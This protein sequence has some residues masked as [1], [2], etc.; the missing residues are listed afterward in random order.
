MRLTI[1]HLALLTPAILGAQAPNLA[2]TWTISL[3]RSTFGPLPSPTYDTARVTR[4]GNLYQIESVSDFAGQGGTR[5]TYAWPVADG[6][7]TNDMTSG[8]TI[9]VTTKMHGDTITFSNTVTVQGQAVG[10]QN[11][12]MYIS[13]G[14]KLLTREVAYQPLAGANRDP[15]HLVLVYD[16]LR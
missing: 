6:E 4:Q 11:G 10:V 2:G 15:V 1:L 13:A 14:G 8:M 3:A 12:R 5:L 9:H 16:R 7:T